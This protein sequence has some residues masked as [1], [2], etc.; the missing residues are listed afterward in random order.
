MESKQF[1]LRVQGKFHYF[2][3]RFENY[4]SRPVWKFLCQMCFGILESG[5]VK[6]SK[7]ALGLGERIS[8][9]KSTERL[10]RHLGR[11]GLCDAVM[12]S[13]LSVQ[14]RSL[15]QCR[16]LLLDLSDIQKDYAERM[17]GLGYVY[18]GSAHQQGL[19]YWLLNVIGVSAD[20]SK[21]VPAYSELYS[22]V[23]ESLSENAQILSAITRVREVVGDDKIW[24]MDRGCDRI[25]LMRRL[26]RQESYFVIRQCGKRSLWV[27]GKRMA[28]NEVSETLRLSYRFT[29]KK[30]H[31]YRFRE[32][33]YRV[34]ARR[35]RLT[36]NGPDLWLIVSKGVPGGY[37]WYLAYLPA[38]S[39]SEAVEMAF[40]GYGY[41][42]KIEEVHRHVKEQYN[43]E[44][45]CLRRYVALKNLNAIFWLAISFIYTQLESLP[46]EF[47]T[48]FN[49]IYKRKLRELLG[50]IYYKLSVVVK[51]IFANCSL[52]LKTLHRW[53]EKSQLSLQLQVY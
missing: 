9:K 44:G 18:D 23:S 26:L 51:M 4:F 12:D 15:R 10:S 7:I 11:S 42:W 53:R 48:H 5:E 30:H 52:R 34:G 40:R 29:V 17:E 37:S 38:P 27:K 49:V 47:F 45:M 36:K 33:S 8:L 6:L 3:G 25:E 35:V 21:I 19:G 46:V 1:G 20:G 43:W 50:F 14:R 16:Y 41:R 32:R 22:F 24:I 39:K 13:L 31:N 28:F 2:L